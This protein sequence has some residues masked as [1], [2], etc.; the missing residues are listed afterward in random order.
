MMMS[1]ERAYFRVGAGR[2]H[3]ETC[4]GAKLWPMT[5]DTGAKAANPAHYRG[6]D[7]LAQGQVCT[8][9]R[10]CFCLA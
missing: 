9:L 6:G 7:G 2:R 1:R 10:T 4:G 8:L 3:V 5:G